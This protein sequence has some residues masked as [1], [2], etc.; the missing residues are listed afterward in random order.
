MQVRAAQ[1]LFGA[2]ILG[3]I[4]QR[5]GV[6]ARGVAGMAG[7]EKQRGHI[8]AR[9]VTIGVGGEVGLKFAEGARFVGMAQRDVAEIVVRAGLGIER[10]GPAQLAQ[11]G[12]LVAV[13]LRDVGGE[14]MAPRAIR[15]LA[16]RDGEL[17]FGERQIAGL[18]GILGQRISRRKEQREQRRKLTIGACPRSRD[19]R[20]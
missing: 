20:S 19:S 3:M 7:L 17:G 4:L 13:A 9:F 14:I 16:Q 15:L 18:L 2:R 6:L 8:D 1:P 12:R 5:R 10:D 11:S